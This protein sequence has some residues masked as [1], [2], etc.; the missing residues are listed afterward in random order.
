[1]EKAGK[2]VSSAIL[3]LDIKTIVVNGKVY[4]IQPPTI[5]TL[6]GV[7]YHLSDL[8]DGKTIADVL[9]CVT[10]GAAS[11]A[12]ALSW[13]IKGDESLYDELSEGTLEEIVNGLDAGFSLISTENFLK[14]SIL[15]KNVATLT[16]K[17]K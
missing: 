14:L 4:R 15:T 9:M 12:K 17:A 16:A 13:F 5:K 11:A 2:I 10:G 3:G 1:M 6:A 8:P 7:S